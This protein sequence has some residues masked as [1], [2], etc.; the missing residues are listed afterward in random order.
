MTMAVLF[1]FKGF[2]MTNAFSVQV[3]G[4]TS[5][6]FSSSDLISANNNHYNDSG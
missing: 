6:H 3:T 4:R 2:A 1:L 5:Y